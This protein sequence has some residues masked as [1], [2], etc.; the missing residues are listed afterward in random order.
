MTL[1]NPYNFVPLKHDG[2][3]RSRGYP[4][5][6]MIKENRY[7]G[8]LVCNLRALS[9]LISLDQRNT[10][11]YI[12][13]D[14]G[15]NPLKNSRGEPFRSIKLF[16]FLRNSE[17]APILQ[18]SS[19][20]GMV[21][22]VYE[23]ITDSCMLFAA[24]SGESK[25]SSADRRPYEYQ[26]IAE[27]RKNRCNNINQICPACRLFG[28]IEGEEVL[29]QGRVAFSDAK[30]IEG[31]LVNE[32][33]FLKE[34]SSPKPHHYATYAHGKTRGKGAPIAGRKFYYHHGPT[35]EFFVDEWNSNDRSTAIG[36]YAPRDTEFCFRLL[37]DNLDQNEM[38]KL[39]LS[40]ELCDGLAH[41]IGVGKAIGLGSCTISIDKSSSSV[42]NAA[43]WYGAW[44]TLTT[45][46]WY[47]LKSG[48]AE[49]PG[50]LIEI[51]RINKAKGTSIG[52]PT[53]RSY[54]K[55]P[56]D[57]YGVFGGSAEIVCPPTEPEEIASCP[58]ED[59]PRTLKQDQ[60]AAWLKQ[61]VGDE[62]I[63]IDSQGERIV[64]PKRGYQGKKDLLQCGKWFILSGTI[65]V[66]PPPR[67]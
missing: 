39:L 22:S 16:S 56:I 24:F 35:P 58:A 60:K 3:D 19:L 65:Q 55:E 14:K 44:D 25:K 12:L 46:D 27:Y 64:R 59:P 26:D 1:I 43:A 48:R 20:K 11:P 42:A 38:A 28:A 53:G 6:H 33:C 50:C 61:I 49:I 7:S 36:E 51:L 15:G 66:N 62:L 32:K 34:L 10:S 30:L 9:P 29:C 67:R 2:P 40:L 17:K 18:G 21:R 4:G 45:A 23:A 8:I 57:A 41:K 52:Y 63:L 31:N 5:K 13:K 47:S 54:P 37:L